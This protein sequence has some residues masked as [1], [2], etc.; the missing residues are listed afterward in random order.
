MFFTHKKIITIDAGTS[1]TRTGDGKHLLF[2]QPTVIEINEKN[3]LVGFGKNTTKRTANK[4]IY[5]VNKAIGDF[6]AFE[7]M[8][9]GIIEKIKIYLYVYV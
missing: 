2:N 6:H 9:R 8:I 5:P 1:H 7:M 4:L 3:D